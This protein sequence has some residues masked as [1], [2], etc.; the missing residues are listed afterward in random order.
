MQFS[1]DAVIQK[2]CTIVGAFGVDSRAYAEAIAIIESGRFPL[3][4]MHTHTFPL[5]ETP[6]AIEVLSGHASGRTAICVSVDP[7]L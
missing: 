4:K 5:A 1:P 6:R 2:G 3:E 7:Q